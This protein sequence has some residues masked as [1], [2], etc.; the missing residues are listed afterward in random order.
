MVSWVDTLG[1]VSTEPWG[2]R[3][4]DFENRLTLIDV[5]GEEVT[6]AYDALG[7]RVSRTL[8]GRASRFS[9]DGEDVV[10]DDDDNSGTTEYQNGPGIDDKL[11][12]KTGSGVK[13]FLQDH[14]G[15]TVGLADA[16]GTVAATQSYDAFGNGADAAFPTRYQFTGREFDRFTGL[17]YSRARWY[18]PGIGRFISEDP[19][20]FAGGDINLYG[21]VWNNPTMFTDPMGLDG[22]G[23]DLANRFDGG[24]E[25]SRRWWKGDPQNWVW[26]GTVDTACDLASGFSDMLRVGTGT[27]YALY[28][29]DENGYGR[30]AYV[31]MDVTRASGL[32]TLLAGAPSRGSEFRPLGGK[33]FRVAPFG[34]RTGHKYGELPH[35]HRRGTDSSGNTI[36]GQGIGRHR[37]WERKSTDKRFQDRF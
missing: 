29:E 15:S 28:A 10:L 19:I 16:A 6:Y 14:L 8:D 20:E 21:Y 7:R 18:H 27:G 12:L 13:Y 17:Q 3:G 32:F 34:N 9:Y 31:A 24:I 5:D 25:Y 26:I 30:G 35:Y 2:E 23:N 22:W 1:P 37:P 11:S 33:D 36:P 4:W